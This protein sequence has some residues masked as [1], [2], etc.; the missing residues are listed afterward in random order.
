MGIR[1]NTGAACILC[2]NVL[3]IAAVCV[4]NYYYLG[5]GYDFSIKCTASGTFAFLG[6]INLLYAFAARRGDMKFQLPMALGL[7][8]ACFGDVLIGYDFIVGAASF[9]IGHICFLIAYCFYRRMNWMDAAIGACLFLASA[10]FLVFCPLLT[11][12]PGFLRIVCIL[13]ALIIGFMT[14]K[15]AGNLLSRPNAYT[16]VAAFGAVLFM[17]SDLMLVFDWFISRW[18]WAG[19]ACMATYYPAL[20]LLAFSMYVKTVSCK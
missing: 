16:A 11:F 18:N 8:F 6:V 13:Y 10:A 12:K 2:V 4:L 19:A 7:I 9:A 3:L 1:K 15:A 20:C 5:G 14:A 17:F